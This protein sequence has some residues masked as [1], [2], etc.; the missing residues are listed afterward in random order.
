MPINAVIAWKSKGK[1]AFQLLFIPLAASLLSFQLATEFLLP[2]LTDIMT[3]LLG[4]FLIA[5]S[6]F[7]L[8]LSGKVQIK[9][10]WI[11]GIIVGTLYGIFAALFSMGGPVM[12]IYLLAIFT[13]LP[14][15]YCNLNLFFFLTSISTNLTRIFNGMFQPSW[16]VYAIIGAACGI[17]GI[18]IGQRIQKHISQSVLKK[19]IYIYVAISGIFMILRTFL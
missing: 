12:A 16:I 8:F 11:T 5:S 1:P 9:P 4:L 15:Y 7:S 6:V 13:D 19:G 14:S 18:L 10:S 2:H 3:L 17:I